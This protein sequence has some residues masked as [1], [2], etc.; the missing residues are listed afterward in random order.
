[1]HAHIPQMRA[2][3]EM[4]MP[5][6]LK[7]THFGATYEPEMTV[8]ML[9]AKGG[10]VRVVQVCAVLCDIVQVHRSPSTYDI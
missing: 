8:L 9:A 3:I 2:Y 4:G 1:M 6:D 10:H 7:G 5:P